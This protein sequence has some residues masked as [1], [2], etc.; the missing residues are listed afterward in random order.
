MTNLIYEEPM[1]KGEA[2]WRLVSKQAFPTAMPGILTGIILSMS[3]AIEETA[4]LIIMGRVYRY[5]RTGL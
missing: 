3:L 1:D 4:P 2:K 5:A